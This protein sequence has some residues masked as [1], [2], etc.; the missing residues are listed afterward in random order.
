MRQQLFE[1][2]H[3][4][5]TGFGACLGHVTRFV[6]AATTHRDVFV[7]STDQLHLCLGTQSLGEGSGGLTFLYLVIAVSHGGQ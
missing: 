4:L 1:S 7:R 2:N 6:V 3:L 5:R